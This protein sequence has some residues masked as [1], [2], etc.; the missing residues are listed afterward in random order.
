MSKGRRWMLIAA[1]AAAVGLVTAGVAAASFATGLT[2]GNSKFSAENIY[3]SF[4]DAQGNQISIQASSGR[5]SFRPRGGGSLITE[6]TST[7]QVFSFVASTGLVGGGCWTVPSS[8]FTIRANDMS[9]TIAFDSSAPGIAECPGDPVNAG[10]AVPS[11]L[12]RRAFSEG[13]N[14]RIAFTATWTPIG[15]TVQFRSTTNTSCGTFGAVIEAVTMSQ[16]SSAATTISSLT[17]EG[18]DPDSGQTI[19]V[20]LAGTYTTDFALVTQ[21]SFDQTVNGPSS[22]SCGPF[23]SD[24]P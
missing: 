9:A 13:L 5:Q 23:G 7:V 6:D 20:S 17:V 10:E 21:G 18:V 16:N 8:P 12:Q 14:G 11:S 2:P 3:A 19:D 24:V 1:G 15:S 22:G 4:I